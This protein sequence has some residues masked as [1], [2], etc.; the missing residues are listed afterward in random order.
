MLLLDTCTLLW[1]ASDVSK[2]S[3]LAK[4]EISDSRG[5]LFVSAITAFELGI[6]HRKG[7]LRL[8]L[9]PAKW[10]AKA[11]EFHGV[12]EIPVNG[13]IAADSTVLPAHHSDPCDRII[14]ATARAKELRIVTPDPLIRAYSEATC[15]W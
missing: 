9:A 5:G 15:L 6:K 12:I 8:P 14:V 3:E 7:A 1:L 2:L 4:R 13:A 11:L 10:F